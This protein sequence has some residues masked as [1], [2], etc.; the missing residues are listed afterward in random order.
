MSEGSQAH[1]I[2]GASGEE[3]WGGIPKRPVEKVGPVEQGGTSGEQGA[4]KKASG[5]GEAGGSK[6][7]YRETKDVTE[8]AAATLRNISTNFLSSLKYKKVSDR[9]LRKKHEK[10]IV[11]ASGC[12]REVRCLMG[13]DLVTRGEDSVTELAVRL[14]L[15]FRHT[16]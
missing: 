13:T 5:A 15:V 4:T 14:T 7:L 12:E 10:A 9:N 1:T 16:Y 11:Q 8:E 3:I 6:E 2:G